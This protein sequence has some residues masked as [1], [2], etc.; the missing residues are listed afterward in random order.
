MDTTQFK[1]CAEGISEFIR[2][3][4]M[5][6][7]DIQHEAIGIAKI[8]KCVNDVADAGQH[9][10][11]AQYSADISN[12]PMSKDDG[13]IMER[14]EGNRKYICVNIQKTGDYV[15]ASNREQVMNMIG[16]SAVS[17]DPDKGVKLQFV[18]RDDDPIYMSFRYSGEHAEELIATVKSIFVDTEL[19]HVQSTI[20]IKEISDNYRDYARKLQTLLKHP[21]MARFAGDIQR[22]EV[23]YPDGVDFSIIKVPIDPVDFMYNTNQPILNLTFNISDNRVIINGNN[24]VVNSAGTNTTVQAVMDK[25]GIG[26][27]K[28][29]INYLK[30][31]SKN[32][33]KQG[34]H[35]KVYYDRMK[36]ANPTFKKGISVHNKYMDA[37]LWKMAR[38]KTG[39]YTWVKM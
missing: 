25:T 11:N 3:Y 21:R 6:H 36:A 26:E 1:S 22:L 12:M 24:N 18:F 39:H 16:N 37:L 15:L 33:P 29:D 32:Q 35:K 10:L 4:K 13:T 30:W 2:A 20:T 28:I 17:G 5:Q 7:R 19:T 14:K 23:E 38:S 34:E 8:E 27:D 31:I 9:A